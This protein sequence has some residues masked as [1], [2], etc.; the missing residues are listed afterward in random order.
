MD[1]Q[2]I[3]L[4]ETHKNQRNIGKYTSP[5]DPMGYLGVS[6]FLTYFNFKDYTL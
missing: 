4:H 6:S 1:E 2:Y 3:Y 5:M